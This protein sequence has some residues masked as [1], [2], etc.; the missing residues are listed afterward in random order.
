MTLDKINKINRSEFH[1]IGVIKNKPSEASTMIE[2]IVWSDPGDKAFVGCKT[3][4]DRGAGV[5]WGKDVTEKFF[6]RDKLALMVRSHECENHGFKTHHDGKCLT[7]FSASHYYG[8]ATNLG[9]FIGNYGD[10]LPAPLIPRSQ[11]TKQSMY[12]G[13]KGPKWLEACR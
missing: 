9:S 6:N 13:S 5:R 8:P 1:S 2:A 10:A 4:T 11:G 12:E 7:L 3:N